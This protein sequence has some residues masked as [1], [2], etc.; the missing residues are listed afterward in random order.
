[1]PPLADIYLAVIKL[2]DHGGYF[3][4]AYRNGTQWDQSWPEEV[5]AWHRAEDLIRVMDID[6]PG[7]DFAELDD[8]GEIPR[9]IEQYEE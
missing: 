9:G 6:W 4:F 3:A 8:L 7:P 1:M 2:G 5:I